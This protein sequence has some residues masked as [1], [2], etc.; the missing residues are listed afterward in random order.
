MSLEQNKAIIRSLYEADNK[1]D[2][3]ILDKYISPDFFEATLQMRGPEPYKQ[4]EIM[5][6]KAFPD[7]QENIEDIIAEG[8]KVWVYFNATGRHMGELN[9]LGITLPPTSKKVEFKAVQMWR[10]VDGMVVEKQSVADEL[11]AFKELGLIEPKG[12]GKK[13]F[14]ENVS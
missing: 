10:L 14:P 3:S 2:L 13:L 7:W 6:F 8:D 11:E 12:E 4:F 9:M 1:K 5:F